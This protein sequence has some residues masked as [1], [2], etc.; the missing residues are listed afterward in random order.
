MKAIVAWFSVLL[1]L[2][3]SAVV[4]AAEKPEQ[5]NGE[6][7][8]EVE[9]EELIPPNFS[10][11]SLF[12]NLP[13]IDHLSEFDD[14]R[15]DM[16]FMNMQAALQ[17]APVREELAGK[18]IKLPGFVVPLEGNGQTAYTF[19]L[20]PYFGACIHMPPPP[21]NQIIHVD[22]EP[23]THIEN[24]YDAVWVTGKLQIERTVNELG[25][26]GYSMQAFRIEPYDMSQFMD[27]EETQ[28]A[29]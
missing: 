20:V 1:M 13:N 8:T 27:S 10:F 7:V 18:M 5:V 14:P 15:A 23:G 3:V 16:A 26:S 4:N 29:G 12:E 21:A 24:L 22:Y 19:F 6:V 17:S 11:E 2:T 28:D 25:A 9:W